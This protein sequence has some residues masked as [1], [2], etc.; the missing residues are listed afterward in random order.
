M[1]G[2]APPTP[3]QATSRPERDRS[4]PPVSPP[5]AVVKPRNGSFLPGRAHLFFLTRTRAHSSAPA[6]AKSG[7]SPFSSVRAWSPAGQFGFAR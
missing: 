7:P 4:A 3:A 6:Q 1:T 5:L 2:C